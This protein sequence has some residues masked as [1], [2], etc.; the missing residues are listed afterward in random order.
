MAINQPP[1]KDDIVQSS[2]EIEVTRD[3]N[4]T[5]Q[6]VIQLENLLAVANTLRPVR[7]TSRAELP[8]NPVFG[9]EIFVVND[10]TADTNA[11][12][13]NSGSFDENT[14]YKFNGTTWSPL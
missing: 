12:S 5:E 1:I 4:S 11:V 14:W 3:V 13:F 2:W 8:N 7:V 10:I 6:R 9:A